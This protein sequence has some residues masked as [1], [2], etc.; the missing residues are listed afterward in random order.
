MDENLIDK[1]HVFL[2]RELKPSHI[3]ERQEIRL[4]K[5]IARFEKRL[6]ELEE[7]EFYYRNKELL[8]KNNGS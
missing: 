2:V 3:L 8:V 5:E 6:K 1:N 7:Y 4:A